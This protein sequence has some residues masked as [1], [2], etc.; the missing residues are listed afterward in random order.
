MPILTT[1]RAQP[2]ERIAVG[3]GEQQ[4]SYGR[5]VAD[6]DAAAA[7]LAAEGIGVGSKL[8]I[9][10]GT[11]TN[12]HSY[13]NWVAHLAAM[14]LGADHVSVVEGA[15]VSAALQAGMIDTVVGSGASF[16][17]LP[18]SLRTITFDV[19]L[20]TPPG[21]TSDLPPSAEA[22]ARRLNLTSGTTGKPKFLAW[23]M[24]MIEARVGQVA[25]GV[26]LGPD[27]I[28]YP[29][30]HIRTTGGFRYPLAVW[31]VGGCVLLPQDSELPARDSAALDK[32]T[33]IAASPVQLA[34]RLRH[35]PDPWD[36]RDARTI[37]VL[38]GRLPSAV[39]DAALVRA[40]TS[41]L[42]SYG[43]TET[44]SIALGEA[45]LIDRHAGAV[46]FVRNRVSVEI[47]DAA[48]AP[49]AAGQIGVVRVKSDVMC[50]GY[51]SQIPG[52]ESANFEGGYFYPGDIGRLLDDGL[53][54]IEG[55]INDTINVG[56]WKVNA[57]DLEARL[58]FLPGVDDL[59]VCVMP[60]AEG[61]L[62]TIAVVTRDTVDLDAVAQR[63]RA[64]LPTGRAFHLVRIRLIPRN[65]MGKI[66]R[67]MI[68]N[69]LTA[70]YGATRENLGKNS[71]NA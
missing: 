57:V 44:G 11:L 19:D 68:A 55:R 41:L 4:L 22:R 47:V 65:E 70:L 23:D 25:D 29:L 26:A 64:E 34:E 51:E 20:A 14:H 3:I 48:R 15:S 1:I 53:L 12:G 27:T 59:C 7:R 60:L 17:A 10:V 56:G 35:F 32:S 66:P 62:L 9:R 21:V 43:S 24:A 63:I 16:D 45:A 50:N 39:R 5:L 2:P 46:G 6:I 8:G 71:A 42:I 40:C 31:Q 54:A 18:P 33:L 61:D 58:A 30:L 37:I 36:G 49:V 38:G 67:A 13:A 52:R 28:F 69:K